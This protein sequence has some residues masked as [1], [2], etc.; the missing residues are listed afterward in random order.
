MRSPE[1]I[2]IRDLLLFGPFRLPPV[3]P[4]PDIGLGVPTVPPGRPQWQPGARWGRR[5]AGWL[6]A[7][8]LWDGPAEDH[9]GAQ[10]PQLTCG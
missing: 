9:I 10:A 8:G 6:S 5:P 4:C 7:V 3:R 1:A 2:R